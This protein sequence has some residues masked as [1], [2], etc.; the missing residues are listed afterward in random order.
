MKSLVPA[1]LQINDEGRQIFR[2]VLGSLN[3]WYQ[4]YFYYSLTFLTICI[5]EALLHN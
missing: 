4:I 5:L 1:T 2:P 3:Y